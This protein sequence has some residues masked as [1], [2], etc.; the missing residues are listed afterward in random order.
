MSSDPSSISLVVAVTYLAAAVLLII[1]FR[2]RS[3]SRSSWRGDAIGA[4]GMLLAI[5]A[6]LLQCFP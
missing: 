4:L 6:T 5:G 3:A 2:L 1:G